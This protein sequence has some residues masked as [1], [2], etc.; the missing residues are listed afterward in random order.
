MLKLPVAKSKQRIAE[1][2]SARKY[3]NMEV[4][5][6]Y[7]VGDDGKSEFYEI[8]MVDPNHPGIFRDR[9]LNFLCKKTATRRV[10]RGLTSAG[11]KSRGIRK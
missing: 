1:E 11:K 8:I 10:H 3:P 9:N 4:L 5:N 6:S 2:R 7:W